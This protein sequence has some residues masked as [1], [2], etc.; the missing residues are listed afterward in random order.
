MKA[1]LL[2]LATLAALSAGPVVDAAEATPATRRTIHWVP[3]Q[4]ATPR[5][6][7]P[8]TVFLNGCFNGGCSITPGTDNAVHGVSSVPQQASRIEPFAHSQ[9]AWRNVVACVQDL[10]APFNVTI[11]DQR[12]ATASFHQAIVAGR[13]EQV[14]IVAGVAGVAPFN[15]GY[16][17]NSVSFAFA[18]NHIVSDDNV[19]ELCW[20]VA[21]EIAH[22]FGLEHKFD[23]RDP[24]TYLD[25]SGE[26]K[27]FVNEAGA[28]GENSQNTCLCGDEAVNSYQKLADLFG[29]KALTAPTVTITEP[30]AGTA[31]NPGFTMRAN[32]TSAIGVLRVEFL[33][34]GT[35]VGTA[36]Q[37]PFAFA[38][39]R[40]LANGLHRVEAVVFDYYGTATSSTIDVVH[41]AAC[42]SQADC[43]DASLTCVSG[44]CVMAPGQ[45]GGLGEA[46][47]TNRECASGQCAAAVDGNTE[48][49]GRCIERCSFDTTSACPLEFTCMQPHTDA[50]A[51]AAD[52]GV[53][54]PTA[55][56]N[57]SGG[58]NAANHRPE[59]ALIGPV[60]LALWALGRR[61]KHQLPR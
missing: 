3:P 57:A 37:A 36:R 22:G 50:E 40:H 51:N 23:V 24:M 45:Q 44:R 25:T 15:C 10:Y 13:P 21:Q 5:G 46:C 35:L 42:A 20:T 31:I 9:T 4:N 54:W 32:A 58:C 56:T 53:C 41:G 6:Q 26:R 60:L 43:D 33:V 12:P 1:V 52:A 16:I 27:R 55:S 38:A 2:V 49:G 30:R 47:A 8:T 11:T 7:A 39:P 48:T 18:N 28:C 59:F 61:Q 34:D 14:Q 17:E 19:N 29:S